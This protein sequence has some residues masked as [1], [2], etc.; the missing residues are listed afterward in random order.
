MIG[1]TNRPWKPAAISF[2][3]SFL[4]G[5]TTL[6]RF[7]DRRFNLQQTAD[8]IE[9][10]P[11]TSKLRIYDYSPPLTDDEVLHKLAERAARLTDGQ[12]KRQLQLEQ[13]LDDKH[14]SS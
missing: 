14:P 9:Y 7:H 4:T 6:F 10:E 3:V 1:V 11:K 12:R 5:I 13:A 8:T 2:L